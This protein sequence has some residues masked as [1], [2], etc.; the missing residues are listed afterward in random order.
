MLVALCLRVTSMILLPIAFTREISPL[1]NTT[2][3]SY[4]KISG[5]TPGR[6]SRTDLMM[7]KI[8]F[9]ALVQIYTK[10]LIIVCYLKLN[11]LLLLDSVSHTAHVI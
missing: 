5:S 4:H 9:Y 11:Q 10:L 3:V 7:R 2:N 8:L 1:L 6:F